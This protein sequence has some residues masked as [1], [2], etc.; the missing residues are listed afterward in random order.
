MDEACQCRMPNAECRNSKTRS[1]K[2][3]ESAVSR[4][5]F[6]AFALSSSGADDD[7]SSSSIIADGIEQPTRRHRTGRP[8]RLPIWPCSVRGF[9]CHPCC[10]GRGALLPH[11]FTLP[12]L[13]SPNLTITASYGGQALAG[14]PDEAR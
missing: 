12:L 14:L 1:S 13:R 9:A 8:Q 11:L 6:L 3:A 5:L 7:H 2:T 10:H 4:I